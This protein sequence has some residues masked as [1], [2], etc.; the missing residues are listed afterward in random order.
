VFS[1]VFD[2]NLPWKHVRRGTSPSVECRP[3]VCSLSRII[4]EGRAC[5]PQ[6]LGSEHPL[7]RVPWAWK[8]GLVSLWEKGR[9]LV[10]RH[11]RHS[12]LSLHKYRELQLCCLGLFVN[13]GTLQDRVLSFKIHRTNPKSTSASQVREGAKIPCWP[14][15][16]IWVVTG[17]KKYRRYFRRP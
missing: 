8:S 15:A 13:L 6:E 14:F 12:Y 11:I 7:S 3:H 2:P 9:L 16:L 5:K 1:L 10:R 4:P 17:A